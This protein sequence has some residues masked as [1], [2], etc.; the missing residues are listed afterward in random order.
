MGNFKKKQKRC[1]LTFQL[2]TL[3]QSV[4]M[5][6]T[7]KL[8]G[9]KKTWKESSQP[10]LFLDQRFSANK[11]NSRCFTAVFAT[12][13]ATWVSTIGTTPTSHSYQ[14]MSFLVRL[15]KLAQMSRSLRL[16]IPSALVAS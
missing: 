11:S 8:P 15:L 4:K 9:V 13:I 5:M 14:V 7:Q 6:S 10:S 3:F 1:N 16:V 12:P 2:S